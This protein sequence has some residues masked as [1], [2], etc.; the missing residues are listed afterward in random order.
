MPS[1][2]AKQAIA[3]LLA[4][5]FLV[6]PHQRV[7]QSFL[8]KATD[9]DRWLDGTRRGFRIFKLVNHLPEK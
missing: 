9:Y 5:H 1:D 8:R 4:G 6:L 7:A 3:G 2:V